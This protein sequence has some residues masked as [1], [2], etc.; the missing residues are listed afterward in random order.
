MCP[1]CTMWPPWFASFLAWGPSL[2]LCWETMS[3]TGSPSVLACHQSLSKGSLLSPAS[4]GKAEKTS[5]QEL[6]GGQHA[7]PHLT[8]EQFPWRERPALDRRTSSPHPHAH[9]RG[10]LRLQVQHGVGPASSS[11]FP[12]S[13]R[14]S[15]NVITWKASWKKPVLLL[16]WADAAQIWCIICKRFQSLFVYSKEITGISN[17]ILM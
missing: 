2:R 4:K 11:C 17:C 3:G 8:S 14:E 12:P 6:S 13:S 5:S 15:S 10:M 7:H 9:T 16:Q 1:S